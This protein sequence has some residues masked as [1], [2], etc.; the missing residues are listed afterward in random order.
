MG[1]FRTCWEEPLVW[2]ETRFQLSLLNWTIFVLP[3]PF[4][5]R[6]IGNQPCMY[7]W[8]FRTSHQ[9]LAANR[10]YLTCTNSHGCNPSCNDTK[11]SCNAIVVP[12]RGPGPGKPKHKPSQSH[13]H[14][15]W[16]VVYMYV[17]M[18]VY[19]YICMIIYSIYPILSYLI[20]SYPILSY[21]FLSFPILSYPIPSI[22]L[23]I[24]LSIYLCIY[25]YIYMYAIPSHGRITAEL[26]SHF[27]LGIPSPNP[28]Y[29]ARERGQASGLCGCDVA[30]DGVESMKDVVDVVDLRFLMNFN[31]V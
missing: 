1:L 28:W 8:I 26:P 23:S 5:D 2:K 9:D 10:G 25:I 18:Y 24:H 29:R 27:P 21:P 12:E 30:G 20:L 7:D 17:C 3:I 15:E 16:W 13:H 31:M 6:P 14:F 22:H 4:T 19:I 11:P